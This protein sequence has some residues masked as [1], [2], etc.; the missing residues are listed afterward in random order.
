MRYWHYCRGQVRGVA[1]AARAIQ[2]GHPRIYQ[3]RANPPAANRERPHRPKHGPAGLHPRNPG[4]PWACGWPRDV[5]W[6]R[7][8]SKTA[9]LPFG[10]GTRTPGASRAFPG[11]SRAGP[12]AE[13]ACA[14]ARRTR[15][16]P[17]HLSG[18][19]NPPWFEWNRLSST[20]ILSSVAYCVTC[21][22]RRWTT[23]RLHSGAHRGSGH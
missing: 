23:S 15:G 8:G 21:C 1:P 12:S 17:S 20:T 4:R 6:I 14:C 5:A 16:R 13:N 7:R 2:K 18:A 9:T 3:R 10:P 11:A 22:G 19:A